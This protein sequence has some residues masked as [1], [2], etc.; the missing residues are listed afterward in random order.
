MRVINI[1]KPTRATRMSAL[2]AVL[3]SRGTQQSIHQYIDNDVTASLANAKQSKFSVYRKEMGSPVKAP[4][5]P[6]MYKF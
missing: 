1:T 5:A 2:T 4:R 3:G 6:A